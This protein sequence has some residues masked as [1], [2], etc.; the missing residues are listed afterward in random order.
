MSE[1]VEP[2]VNDWAPKP[3]A[4]IVRATQNAEGDWCFRILG[5]RAPDSFD[6]RYRIEAVKGES[7]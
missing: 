5:E 4:P 7:S 2:D 1:W 3:S 6:E